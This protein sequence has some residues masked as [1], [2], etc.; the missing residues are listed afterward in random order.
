MVTEH[1][2]WVG[3]ARGALYLSSHS[4]RQVLFKFSTRQ[5]LFTFLQIKKVRF[6]NVMEPVQDK[7][8][9]NSVWKDED[10]PNVWEA[11]R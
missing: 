6:R 9:W 8:C 4:L 3:S 7:R 5:I 11:G 10:E 2:L 1:L